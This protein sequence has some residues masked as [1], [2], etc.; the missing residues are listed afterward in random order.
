MDDTIEVLPQNRIDEAA[1]AALVADRVA[2]ATGRI[3]LRQFPGG[4]SNPTYALRVET[5]TGWRDLV[6][7]K[8]PAGALLQSAH[9]VD[10]E[11]RV[12]NALQG[13]DVPVPK[14]LFFVYEQVLGQPFYIME[15]VEGRIFIQPTLPDLSAADRKS[16]YGSAA[17]VLARLHGVDPVAVGLGGFGRHGGYARRQFERWTKQYRLAQTGDIP[18]MEELIGALDGYQPSDD[19]TAIAHG[20]YRLGNLIFDPQKPE[21]VAVLDWE[22]STLGHPLCDLAYFCLCYHLEE[23][24]IGFEG[25]D[26]RALGI[27]DE[28]ELIAIYCDQAGLSHVA[29]WPFYLAISLFKLASISQGVYKRALDGNATTPAALER[30]RLVSLRAATALRLLRA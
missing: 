9:Q 15:R 16:A 3:E 14:T 12:L 29:D 28:N 8:K 11:Y 6:M 10:R 22:L 4:F 26:Y 20:D 24:P 23:A 18:E 7:R 21:I 2:G 25:A 5:G 13:S 17:R 27:P 30:G 19:R 1:L